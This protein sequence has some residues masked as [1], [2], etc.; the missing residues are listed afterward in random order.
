VKAAHPS[1][2]AAVAAYL[3]TCHRDNL[4]SG[5]PLAA[6][7]S[8]LGRSHTKARDT[9]RAGFVKLM[10][11]LV[12]NARTADARRRA[13]VAAAT[14]IGAMTNSRMVT[15]PNLSVAILQEAEGSLTAARS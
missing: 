14:L 12:E 15:D 10:D 1:V 7:G 5:C 3:S 2:S 6:I 4:A 13:L 9:A 11:I 8:E